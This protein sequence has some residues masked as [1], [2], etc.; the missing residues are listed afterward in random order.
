MKSTPVAEIAATVSRV[1][2]ARGLEGDRRS[3]RRRRGRRPRRRGPRGPCCR[4][5]AGAAPAARAGLDVG[6]ITALDLD[7]EV[8][9]GGA[10]RCDRLLEMPPARAMWFSLIRIASSRPIRWFCPP[11]ARTAA[12][13]SE[14]SS[15]V[16]LRV[17]RIT[18][19]PPSEREAS[20]KRAV[21]V[22]TPER[23]PSRLRATRSPASSARAGPATSATCRGTASD[24][25]PST[26]ELVELAG[27]GL[28]ER[29]GGDVEAED[30]AGLL[31]DDLRAP[32]ARRPGRSRR[33]SGRRPRGPRR[34]PRATSS[35]TAGSTLTWRPCRRRSAAGTRGR[36]RRGRRR[37][38][39][40]RRPPRD[41]SGGP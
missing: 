30:D 40:G 24:Q 11:P 18:A 37:A 6:G 2:A 12:F 16:V 17:S 41:R 23:W 19:R 14:R 33:W 5:A 21:S 1:D 28:A 9:L 15:G 25:V 22:A 34:A 26:I 38:R 20:T 7:R 8:R 29:L 3:R 4:A 27:A 35:P 32:P 36:S 13:S 10:R 39:A 31:L